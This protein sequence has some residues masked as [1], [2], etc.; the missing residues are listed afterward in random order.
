MRLPLLVLVASVA[1]STSARAQQVAAAGAPGAPSPVTRADTAQA[2]REMAASLRHLVLAQET[3][4]ATHA[5]YTTDAV[6]LGIA[7][8]GPAR[9]QV[10]F[11]GGRGWT[12]MSSVRGLTGRSCVMFVG[13]ADETPRMPMT[14]ADRRT[15]T[16]AQE[17]Q[18]VCD[19]P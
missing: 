4:Y 9:A 12:A 3:Y 10:I 18:P 15:P 7:K 1:L 6:A 13:S 17:G 16:Q 8:G 19:T 5:S 2:F 14:L 11:A